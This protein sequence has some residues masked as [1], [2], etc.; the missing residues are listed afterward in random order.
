MTAEK[1]VLDVPADVLEYL[2]EQNTLTLA[3]VSKDGTPHA[4][5][6]LYVNE[7]PAL[8]FW[9]HAGSVTARH[10]DERP[11]VA[12]AI[13]EYA[14]DLRQ[15]RGV[16]GTGECRSIAGEEIARVAD[17]FGQKFPSLSPGSTVSIMFFSI[18]PTELQFID[19]RESSAAAPEGTFGAEFHSRRI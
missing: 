12:F 17:I 10:I 14:S 16:K 1:Q 13:D 4:S 7:G 18:T 15:T 11:L 8:Y 9:A 2:G 19:N 6:F 3:A 5:T